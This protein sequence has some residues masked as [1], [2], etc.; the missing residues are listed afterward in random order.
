MTRPADQMTPE[1]ALAALSWQCDLGADEA[2]GET[3]VN[4]YCDAPPPPQ[5]NAAPQHNARHSGPGTPPPSAP[6]DTGTD[7]AAIAAGCATLADLRDAIAAFDGCAL[8]KGA[9]NLVFA[10]GLP[11]AHVMI[12]GEA[13]GRDEDAQGLP[14]VG[15]SGQL[16]DRMFAAI[17]LSRRA[18]DPAAALYIT[19]MLPWR[20]PQNRDPSPEELA[21]MRPF[22][23]RHIELAAPRVL[24]TMGNPATR[25]L[26]R[27]TEGIT[28]I[29][30][31]WRE[32]LGIP[33]LPMFHPAAILR[34]PL[35]KRSAWSDLLT[36]KARLR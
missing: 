18:E 20:P 33:A 10:D 1:D 34:D 4:R 14:F 25:T 3:P 28:G 16:L 21:M 24:V 31:T 15:A 32:V 13:P 30:G 7:N 22:L 12:V 29:R 36:L 17:G 6:S 35:K 8:K 9:R 27:T 11:G 2:I 23:V 5:G 26:L 19:N